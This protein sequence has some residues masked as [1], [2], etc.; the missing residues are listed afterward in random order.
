MKRLTL[1]KRD[2]VY[3]APIINWSNETYTPISNKFIMNMIDDKINS[4]GLTVKNESYKASTTKSGLIT[5]VI[6]SYD[7][8]ADNEEFG[9]RIMFRNS[10]DKSMSF[11]IVCGT[12]VWICTNGCISGDYQFKRIHRGV[13]K[14]IQNG[15]VVEDLSTTQEDI[16]Q[17]I[18]GGFSMLQNAF[19]NVVKQMNELKHFE[20]SP[21]ETFG[22]LG[23]LFFNKEVISITQMSA[24]KRELQ[25]S[26]HFK[27]FGDKDF[28]AYD[29]YNDITEVLKSSHPSVYI[30]NHIDTHNLFKETFNLN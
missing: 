26:Q 12:C 4:L 7:I 15:Y 25:Y 23:E 20:I 16:V 27:H 1:A 10:Y 17:N 3:N 2:E 18:D 24:I 8:T 30:S 21:K 13:N 19:E 5:G 22:I 14:D 29:L 6:G 28:T 9:Q 11:A